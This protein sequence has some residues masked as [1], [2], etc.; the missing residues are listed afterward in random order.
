MCQNVQFVELSCPSSGQGQP[1]AVA[2]MWTKKDGV[3]TVLSAGLL[4]MREGKKKKK[5]IMREGAKGGGTRTQ[6]PADI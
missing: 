3:S 5:K 4:I 6:A 1:F 2:G